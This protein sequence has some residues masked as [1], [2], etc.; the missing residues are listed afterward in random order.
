MSPTVASSYEWTVIAFNMALLQHTADEAKMQC[1]VELH[2]LLTQVF[3]SL[4]RSTQ[5]TPLT[6]ARTDGFPL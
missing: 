4:K 5:R 6:L 2:S 3:N 1:S